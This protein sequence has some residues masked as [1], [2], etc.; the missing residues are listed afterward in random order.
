M[1]PLK[2]LSSIILIGTLLASCKEKPTN[3][4]KQIPITAK[5]PDTTVVEE[6]LHQH[7]AVLASDEFEG[8]APAT[9]GEEKTVNYLET[10]FKSLGVKPGNGDSYF[11]SVSVTEISTA[12]NAVL[13]LKGSN[14]EAKLN[15]GTEMMAGSQQQIPSITLSDSA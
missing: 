7:I 15:Y 13:T 5:T 14:Y 6:I 12:S 3:S 2:W 4:A 11:Q 9:P 10:E 1:K 8:R